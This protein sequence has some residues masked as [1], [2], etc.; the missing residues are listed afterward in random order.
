MYTCTPVLACCRTMYDRRPSAGEV[1]GPLIGLM[2]SCP[3]EDFEAG[4]GSGVWV[5]TVQYTQAPGPGTAPGHRW[6]VWGAGVHP[7]VFAPPPL[8]VSPCLRLR[9]LSTTGRGALV[10]PGCLASSAC[11][12]LLAPALTA[13][14]SLPSPLEQPFCQEAHPKKTSKWWR[15]GA[16]VCVCVCVSA[17]GPASI[18]CVCI[19]ARGAVASVASR[20]PRGDTVHAAQSLQYRGAARTGNGVRQRVPTA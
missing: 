1:T 5:Q 2:I 9:L 15:R 4:G 11:A 18:A 16:C 6:G 20:W 8:P 19:A 3:D 12:F 17:V 13:S 14:C 10:L 7:T